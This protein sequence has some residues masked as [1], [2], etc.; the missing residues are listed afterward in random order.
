MRTDRIV[1]GK[2]RDA[3]A[4]C[5]QSPNATPQVYTFLVRSARSN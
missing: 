2:A 3:I 5:G 1:N 4:L